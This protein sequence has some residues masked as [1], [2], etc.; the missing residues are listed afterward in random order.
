MSRKVLDRK[1]PSVAGL[2]VI[3]IGIVFTTFLVKGPSQ[4][5]IQANPKNDP[6]NVQITNVSDT[7]FTVAYVTDDKVIGTIN[8]ST[9][10]EDLN[11]IALDER[12][13]LSQ[14]VNEYQAHSITANN[15][16]PNTSYYF[17]IT[18]G[19]EKFDNN[20]EPYFAKT[21]NRISAPPSTQ[22]PMAGTI[23]NPDG[24]SISDGIVFVTIS[25]AGKISGLVKNKGN[26]TIPLNNLRSA[27]LGSYYT[28]DENSL[29]QIEAI[30][31]GLTSKVDTTVSRLSPVPFITLSNNYDFKMEEKKNRNLVRTDEERFPTTNPED[32]REIPEPTSTTAPDIN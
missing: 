8:Y 31:N 19:D 27:D 30:A 29:I 9:N 4:F 21:G 25:G 22:V 1:I 24:T 18:S 14:E 32:L 15:L 5:Q 16:E 2:G 20:G 28:I 6:V 26:Y 7:S 23:L 17:T 13:Q 12:D 11:N 10:P 3:V